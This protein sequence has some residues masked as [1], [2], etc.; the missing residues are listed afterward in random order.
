MPLV[1]LVKGARYQFANV[2]VHRG[3][4]I[5]V[6]NKTRNHLVK[7]THFR[8]VTEPE[9]EFIPLP[10]DDDDGDEVEAVKGGT[11]LDQIDSPSLTGAKRS[12]LGGKPRSRGRGSDI[13]NQRAAQ[14]KGNVKVATKDADAEAEAEEAAEV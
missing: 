9:P 13:A 5:E 4:V 12:D 11:S 10:E 7:S 14:Q 1:K 8:D 2:L 3:E 6:D